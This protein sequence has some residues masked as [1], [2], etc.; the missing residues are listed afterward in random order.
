MQQHLLKA[1][2]GEKEHAFVLSF[3]STFHWLKPAKVTWQ[4]S[5]GHRDCKVR[6]CDRQN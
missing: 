6:L 1:E 5:L 3:V 4:S 2:K